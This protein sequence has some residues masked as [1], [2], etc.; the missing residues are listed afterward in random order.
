[1]CAE[2]ALKSFSSSASVG[3]NPE[4]DGATKAIIV[5]QNALGGVG[6]VARPPETVKCQ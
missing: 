5:D 2:A 3:S 6:A 4:L 1:M